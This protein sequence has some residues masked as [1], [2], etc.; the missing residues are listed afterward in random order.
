MG[1]ERDRYFKW[2]EKEKQERGLLY[3]RVCTEADPSG[4]DVNPNPGGDDTSEEMYRAL[5]EANEAFERGEY[6]EIDWGVI[7]G[8][9]SVT[10]ATPLP[11]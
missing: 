3:T 4:P 10:L 11:E 9:F 1:T 7:D 6:T 5:N 2:V 8:D